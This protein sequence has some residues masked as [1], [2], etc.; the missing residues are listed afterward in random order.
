MYLFLERGEGRETEWETLMWERNIDWFPLFCT[1]TGDW[2]RNAGMCPD[3]G[4][5]WQL[6][7]LWDNAQPTLVRTITVLYKG[8]MQYPEGYKKP[9]SMD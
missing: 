3:W 6:F 5:N 7:A 9:N 1:P 8:P 4:Y 2:T